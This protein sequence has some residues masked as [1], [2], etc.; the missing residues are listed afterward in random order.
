MMGPCGVE[1]SE[2]CYGNLDMTSG[3]LGGSVDRAPKRIKVGNLRD[4]AA[5]LAL[6]GHL[7]E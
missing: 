4:G 1:K 3:T 2:I 5:S 7:H 6:N